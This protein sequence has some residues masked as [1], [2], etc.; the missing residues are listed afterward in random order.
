M[1]FCHLFERLFIEE[2]LIL[3]LLIRFL[4]VQRNCRETSHA[5]RALGWLCLWRVLQLLFC[6]QDSAEW[7]MHVTSGGHCGALPP[8][9]LHTCCAWLEPRCCLGL[10]QHVFIPGAMIGTT[11]CVLEV[12]IEGRL[13]HP[14]YWLHIEWIVQYSGLSVEVSSF[15][16]DF[17]WN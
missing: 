9:P 8:L 4:Q 2:K 10:V 6:T 3:I 14:T 11:K 5:D 12:L 13:S 15:G 7:L 17:N 1:T 16:W